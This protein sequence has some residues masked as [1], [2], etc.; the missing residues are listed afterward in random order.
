M[1]TEANVALRGTSGPVMF[2]R[3]A[4]TE[5]TPAAD[6]DHADSGSMSAAASTIDT[7]KA[8]STVREP[9]TDQT[10]PG[11]S[12]LSRPASRG[13]ET[14]DR[15]KPMVNFIY[16]V[17]LTRTPKTVTERWNPRGRLQDKTMAELIREL[18]FEADVQGLMFTIEGPGMKTIERI[19]GDDED[20]FDSM[21]RYI[22]TEIRDWFSRSRRQAGDTGAA[23]RL[24][25]D[26]LIE[27]MSDE[28]QGGDEKS[29]DL[30]LDW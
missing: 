16:R 21:K 9:S 4:T 2:S 14:S 5:T 23:P 18:P 26:L 19:L 30:E 1:T 11:E 20:G 13:P 28:D 8:N 27:R 29:E 12:G 3:S 6:R 22:N 10:T 15:G 17:V 7:S 24:V 25:L